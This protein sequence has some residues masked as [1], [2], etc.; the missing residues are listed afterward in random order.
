MRNGTVAMFSR[1]TICIYIENEILYCLNEILYCFHNIPYLFHAPQHPEKQS[2]CIPKNHC[3]IQVS[4]Y[5]RKTRH[6]KKTRQNQ[7]FSGKGLLMSKQSHTFALAIREQTDIH[8]GVEQLVARQAHNLEVARSSRVSATT[9]NK[10]SAT[11]CV[12]S[13]G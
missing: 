8:R 3:G 9:Q 13:V 6:L 10:N 11:W 12:S 7:N 1:Y 5:G 2:I 4:R